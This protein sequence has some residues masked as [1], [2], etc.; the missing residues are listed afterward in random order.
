MLRENRRQE[1]ERALREETAERLRAMEALGEKEQLLIQQSRL[2]AMGEM[3]GNIAHQWRQPLNL[4]AIIAQKLL[5][6]YDHDKFD[7]SF[8]AEHVDKEMELIRN[9]SKTIDDFT[10]Y[11]K[12]ADQK[13]EFYLRDTITD[14][15]SLLNGGLQHT[16]I[17]VE[18]V[19]K[20]EIGIHGYRNE[21]AQVLLNILINAKDVLTEREVVAPK[22]TIATSRAGGLAVV[23][24][25]DNGGGIPEDFIGKIFDPYF[26]TKGPQQGT[27]IGLYMAK[28]ILEKNMGG[29]LT[30]RNIAG[31]AEFRIELLI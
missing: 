17:C 31:G 3:I 5:L 14:V 6:F 27:G 13:T 10:N 4:L 25:A 22:V 11:F 7:R 19:A 2:A 15:L 9:M 23:T 30:A 29:R 26:T 12:P 20:D 24:I 16:G 8:L 18:I 21:F 1:A 28:I